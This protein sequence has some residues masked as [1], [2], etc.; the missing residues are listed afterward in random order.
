MMNL[1]GPETL[2]D[3]RPFLQRLFSDQYA[4]LFFYFYFLSRYG[5]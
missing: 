1:G 5:S 4:F 3:V 2:S